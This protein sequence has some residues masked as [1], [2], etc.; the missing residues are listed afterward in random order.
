VARQVRRLAAEEQKRKK[1]EAKR[2]AH[3]K[4]VALDALEKHRRA[5]AREGLPLKSS[6]STKEDD[7][8]DDDDDDEGMEVHAGFS[9]EA[10]LSSA[11]AP[12][13][14]PAAQT[15]PR[16][17]WHHPCSGAWASASL[18]SSL[19]MQRGRGHGRGSRAPSR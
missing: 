5:Q 10:G 11:P 17:G 8:D 12:R 7:D 6:P 13:A 9:P 19:P 16:R 18:L 3:R 2:W 14:L 4:M 15:F 1:D